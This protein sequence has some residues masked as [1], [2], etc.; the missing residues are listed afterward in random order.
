MIIER[1]RAEMAA[2]ANSEAAFRPARHSGA[3]GFFAG[4]SL[5]IAA[6]VV[7]YYTL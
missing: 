4:L 1:A 6:G 7:L 2:I 3:V 5:S